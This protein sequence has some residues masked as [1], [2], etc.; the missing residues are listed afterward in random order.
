MK[1]ITLHIEGMTCSHCST[2]VEK[3]LKSVPG[4]SNA[5]VSLEE[6]K[7]TVSGEALDPKPLE[8]AVIDAGYQVTRVE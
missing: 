4:V 3:A 8:K 1:T 7:A 2:R 6:K 5:T